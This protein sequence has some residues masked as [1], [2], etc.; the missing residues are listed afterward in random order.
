MN[1]VGVGTCLSD[2]VLM[3]HHHVQTVILAVKQLLEVV[4]DGV[5]I[6]E[7][8]A[9]SRC[10]TDGWHVLVANCWYV[11]NIIGSKTPVALVVVA[12]VVVSELSAQLQVFVNL[13]AEC[14]G[15]VQVLALL[16]LV[17][18]PLCLDRIVEVTQ[19][20]VGSTCRWIE[21]LDG[22]WAVDHSVAQTTVR[23]VHAGS[24]LST[25]TV[26]VGHSVAS[27]EVESS[28]LGRLGVQ[29]QAEVIALEA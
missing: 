26:N 10:Q 25:T 7:A 22:E 11:L 12:V 5:S 29:F 28:S 3:S 15:Q 18:V 21:V 6:T 16:L 9:V 14:T 27:L 1:L 17:V 8:V 4:V 20:V 13:P 19:V 23:V 24:I 2:D